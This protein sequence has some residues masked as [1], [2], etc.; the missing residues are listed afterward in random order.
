M[1]NK[2]KILFLCLAGLNIILIATILIFV[3][4]PVENSPVR[5]NSQS[6][7]QIPFQIQS[8]KQDLNQVINHYL[9]DQGNG[10]IEYQIDLD[11]Y[12][13]LF[14][15]ITVFNENLEM[16]VAFE[17]EATENGDLLLKE[18]SISIGK[19]RLPAEYVLK[20]VKE[21]YH[22]PELILIKPNEKMVYVNLQKLKL[23]GDLGVSVNEF[24]L[25]K[26]RISFTMFVPVNK[27]VSK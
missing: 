13:N 5:N 17:P 2:W 23:K 12:V 14:G 21:R 26:N 16:K 27:G 6:A 20:F 25:K 24:D 4:L 1:K 22:F 10:P 11:D 15:E 8:N 7:D 9:Q 18:K 3:T 19:L